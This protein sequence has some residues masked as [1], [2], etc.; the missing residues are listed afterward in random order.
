MKKI[1]L[2]ALILCGLFLPQWVSAQTE[3]DIHLKA[4]QQAT[5]KNQ[6]DLDVHLLALEVTYKRRLYKNW[7][8]GGSVL[9]GSALGW[10]YEDKHFDYYVENFKGEILLDYSFSEK[11][12][13]HIG[14]MYGLGNFGFYSDYDLFKALEVGLF[15]KI[16]KLEIGFQPKLGYASETEELLY[17]FPV[18]NI[19]IPIIRW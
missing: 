17:F 14:A 11:F 4:Q 13:M 5:F 3:G 2:L 19:K 10:V 1:I 15:Y 12:H 9:F 18:I 16:W 7:F 8:I 6:F